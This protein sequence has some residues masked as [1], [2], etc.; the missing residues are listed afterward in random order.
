[1]VAVAPISLPRPGEWRSRV[2]AALSSSHSQ[3]VAPRAAMPKKP[4]TWVKAESAV[5]SA[6][7]VTTLVAWQIGLSAWRPSQLTA[8]LL[9]PTRR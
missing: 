5:S 1:M 4:A 3:D 6:V 8:S 9:G 7:C 2:V